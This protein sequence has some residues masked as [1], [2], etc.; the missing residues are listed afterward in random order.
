MESCV[1]HVVTLFHFV[2]IDDA[3]SMVSLWSIPLAVEYA[4][5]LVLK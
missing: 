4:D 1:N 3:P 2:W 5:L